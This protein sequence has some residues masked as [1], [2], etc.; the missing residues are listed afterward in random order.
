ME[1]FVLNRK[2]M[3]DLLLSLKGKLD[4]TPLNLIQEVWLKK[5]KPSDSGKVRATTVGTSLPPIIEKIMK[6][7]PANVAF[8]INEIVS[9]A[10][11]LEYNTISQTTVQ[12]WVKRDVRELIGAPSEGKKYS[13]DQAATIFIIEDLKTILDLDSIRKL[14]TVM[15]ITPNDIGDDL[16]QPVELYAAYSTIFEDLDTDDDQI[17]DVYGNNKIDIKTLIE[18]KADHFVH[19]LDREQ[20]E[21]DTIS[22]ILV[23]AT[24]SVQTSYFQSLAKR[25]MTDLFLTHLH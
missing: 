17:L 24:L 9:L 6:L 21:K 7:K 22:D 8:S 25:A 1:T 20:S 14:L 23:I 15:F 11:L 19:S 3:A 18:R 16:L 13:I 2:E 5:Y 10:N 12:N 4:K